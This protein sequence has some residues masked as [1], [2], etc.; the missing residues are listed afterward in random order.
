MRLVPP[1]S[2]GELLLFHGTTLQAAHDILANGVDVQRGKTDRDFGQGF[3]CTSVQSQAT[4]WAAIKSS[5]TAGQPAVVSFSIRR[6]LL[7]SLQSLVFV[8]GTA[9][10]LDFWRFVQ[11]CRNGGTGHGRNLPGQGQQYDL[12]YGPISL[13][14]QSLRQKPDTDQISFHT[15]AAQRVLN[16]YGHRSIL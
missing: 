9:Q 16:V 5:R 14:W 12:V 2:N 1:W 11:F 6:D 10:A 3:Y 15:T 7:A 8:L 13:D 4:E